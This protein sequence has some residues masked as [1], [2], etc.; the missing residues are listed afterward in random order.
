M[1]DQITES[2]E[3]LLCVVCSKQA[4]FADHCLHMFKKMLCAK[5]TMCTVTQMYASLYEFFSP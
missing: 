1:L 4:G 5:T 2:N 3:L